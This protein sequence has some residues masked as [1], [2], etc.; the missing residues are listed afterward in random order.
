MED[1]KIVQLY[2]DRNEAAITA[3]SDKYGTYCQTIL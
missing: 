1:D 2:W 3:T